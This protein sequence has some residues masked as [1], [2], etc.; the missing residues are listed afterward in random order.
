[1]MFLDPPYLEGN[2]LF[3]FS[4]EKR[5]RFV[6]EPNYKKS[7]LVNTAASRSFNVDRPV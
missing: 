2:E 6:S 3:S 1:M 4:L 7:I 5:P